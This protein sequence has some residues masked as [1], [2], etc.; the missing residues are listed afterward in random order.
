M[1]SLTQRLIDSRDQ[2]S[3]ARMTLSIPGTHQRRVR[4]MIGSGTGG[5]SPIRLWHMT[6]LLQGSLVRAG[7][8][9]GTMVLPYVDLH[10]PRSLL[11]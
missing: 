2:H 7:S 9:G 8:C 11:P 1:V 10:V 5:S 3:L 6:R 4:L